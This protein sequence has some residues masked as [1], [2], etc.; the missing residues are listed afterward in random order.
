MEWKR[1]VGESCYMYI[2]T[3]T[4][5]N[6]GFLKMF[7]YVFMYFKELF[8]EDFSV[9]FCF[10]KNRSYD[11]DFNTPPFPERVQDK[12]LRV[13]SDHL[14]RKT[15]PNSLEVLTLMFQFQFLHAGFHIA[16]INSIAKP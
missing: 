3:L 10:V 1:G 8:V 5:P 4:Q 16:S 9:P 14:G 11:F 2:P 6:Y 15:E 13:S 7:V 12:R